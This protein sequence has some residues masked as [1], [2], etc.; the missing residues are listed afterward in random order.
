MTKWNLTYVGEYPRFTVGSK[1]LEWKPGDTIEVDGETAMLVKA[2]FPAL[3]EFDEVKKPEP[4][5]R[6][7]RARE[8]PQEGAAPEREHGIPVEQEHGLSPPEPPAVGE[9]DKSEE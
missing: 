1:G 2:S 4:P 8:A 7:R 6:R 9:E 3:F 5:R